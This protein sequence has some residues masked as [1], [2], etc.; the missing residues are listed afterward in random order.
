[1]LL[2]YETEIQYGRP[3]DDW[4]ELLGRCPKVNPQMQQYES[5][6]CHALHSANYH[7]LLYGQN[8]HQSR[9]ACTILTQSLHWTLHPLYS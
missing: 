5:A 7:T 3:K 6:Q 8:V 4:G 1:M 9:L 2:K